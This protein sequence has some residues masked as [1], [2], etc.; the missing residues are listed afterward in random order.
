M[1]ER[2]ALAKN[3]YTV[4]WV[5]ALPLEMA[6]AKGI[7]REI[8][9]DLPEQDTFDHNSYILGQIHHHNVVIA[10]LTPGV[11]SATP[12]AT[13]AKDMLGT[14]SSIRLGLMA[15]IGGHALFQEVVMCLL[16]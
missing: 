1:S 13:V 12:A 10:S 14:F 8:H 5:C 16:G 9:Q 6:A 11:C 15:A 2:R 7:F 4:W 3:D